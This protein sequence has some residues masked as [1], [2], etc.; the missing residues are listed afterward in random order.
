MVP[1]HTAGSNLSIN[2]RQCPHTY[3]GQLLM[4]QIR[5]LR[6]SR[7][8]TRILLGPSRLR[9]NRPN[10]TG[11]SFGGYLRNQQHQWHWSGS[12]LRSIRQIINIGWIYSKKIA[13]IGSFIAKHAWLT[14]KT[15][16]HFEDITLLRVNNGALYKSQYVYMQT[17]QCFF[18]DVCNTQLSPWFQN[19]PLELALATPIQVIYISSG[20]SPP[21]AAPHSTKVWGLPL[22]LLEPRPFVARKLHY[23]QTTFCGRPKRCKSKCLKDRYEPTICIIHVHVIWN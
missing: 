17:M 10:P 9:T 16:S 22:P 7:I 3:T 11:P 8:R 2:T 15:R 6:R 13:N 23:F 19:T 14:G 20:A 18:R 21:G 5:A 4:M 1:A 12:L